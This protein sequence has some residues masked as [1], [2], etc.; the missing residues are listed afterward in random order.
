VGI[1]GFWESRLPELLGDQYDYFAGRAVYISKPQE[2][3]WKIV[4][5]SFAALDSVLHF[6]R[7]L[8][9]SFASDQKFAFEQR[10]N[11][12][13]KVYSKAY[14]EAYHEML[15][16]MV[17]RRMQA[18]ILSVGSFWY[19]AWVNAGSPD[20]NRLGDKEASD[21]LLIKLKEEE[22]LWKKGKVK[23]SHGHENTETGD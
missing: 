18:A 22:E 6:E 14:S 3:T 17:E 13:A 19:T 7:D 10:G 2:E 1:H 8:N 23:G 20:L 5:A 11:A 12:M 21:S 16:G 4:K 9:K 15:S